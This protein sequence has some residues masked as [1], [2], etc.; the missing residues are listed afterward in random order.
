M[1]L[2][3]R[4]RH[5]S[6]DEGGSW[7]AARTISDDPRN[8]HGYQSLMFLD[9]MAVMSYHKMGGLYVARIGVDWFYGT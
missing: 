3:L 9:D 5:L 4:E 8:D 7:T 1:N 2:Q 6:R